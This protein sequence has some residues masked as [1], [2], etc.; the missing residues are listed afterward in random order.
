MNIWNICV[1]NHFNTFDNL[2]NFALYKYKKRLWEYFKIINIFCV[3]CMSMYNNIICAWINRLAI[4]LRQFYQKELKSSH[5]L[6]RLLN[7]IWIYKY[8]LFLLLCLAICVYCV[9][10]K[11]STREIFDISYSKDILIDWKIAHDLHLRRK[12]A[13]LK[14]GMMS[15]L[16]YLVNVL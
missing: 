11:S 8:Y 2:F 4:F 7:I 1:M 3:K 16:A 6:R 10:C 15:S 12:S 14:I 5:I 13:W 9:T